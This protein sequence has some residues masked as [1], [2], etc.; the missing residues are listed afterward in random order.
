MLLCHFVQ[1]ISVLIIS[2]QIR[3]QTVIELVSPGLGEA[4]AR[5][6]RLG[7]RGPP[8]LLLSPLSLLLIVVRVL[9]RI[10]QFRHQCI[11]YP[12]IKIFNDE[13]I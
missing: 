13:G 8:L 10:L 5:L 6:G 2:Q 9:V 3:V 4:A 1:R 12:V 7:D 11:S